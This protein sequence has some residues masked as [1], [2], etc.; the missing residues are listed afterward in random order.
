[1]TAPADNTISGI[2][3]I[4]AESYDDVGIARVDFI[5]SDG[6]SGMEWRISDTTAPYSIT[7]DTS[8]LQGGRS[9]VIS[10]QAFD[11]SGNTSMSP[12]ARHDTIQ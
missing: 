5:I 9:F 12:Y 7:L 4:T 2:V 1:M 10:A 3:T 8:G 6:A 11:T